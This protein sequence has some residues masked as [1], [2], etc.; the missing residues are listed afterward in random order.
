MIR[1]GTRKSKLALWQANTVK[2]LLEEHALASML[3]PMSSK[4]DLITNKPLHQIGGT[5]LFTK[6]LDDALLNKEAD[7]AVHSLKDYPTVIPEG[8][9]LAAVL[10][11]ASALD[12]LVYKGEKNLFSQTEAKGSILTGSPRRKAQ[13][14]HRYPNFEVFGLRGNVPTRLQKLEDSGSQGAVF[15]KA[16]LDRLDI[17]PENHLLL[18]W[19]IPAPAQGI[20]ALVCR[21]S[22]QELIQKLQLLND[23]DA[24]LSGKIERDF[25]NGV[26]GGCS[27]PVGAHAVIK[28]EEIHFRAKVN[29]LDG[30]QEVYLE[31]VIA[32]Q[33]AEDAGFLF[34]STAL[35]AGADSIIE[36]IKR[37]E[38]R[39]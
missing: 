9:H 1:I 30:K 3:H 17:L 2:A 23:E 20:I 38:L 6:V 37:E 22:E 35:K 13:W 10:P 32:K 26:E 27:A 11:R 19:M 15:A 16:G 8:L 33:G 29:S 28:G 18:D 4:G 36:E 12:V 14:L 5:G 31:E 25:L 24:F 34:A 39:A 7:L 21:S